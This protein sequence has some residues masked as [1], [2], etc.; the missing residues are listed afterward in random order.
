M[1]EVI[2]AAIVL[3]VGVSIIFTGITFLIDSVMS[4]V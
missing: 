1:R 2:I 4:V 3:F